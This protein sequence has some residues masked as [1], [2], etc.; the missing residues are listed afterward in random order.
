MEMK[1]QAPD[2]SY[3]LNITRV[4]TKSACALSCGIDPRSFREED[5]KDPGLAE[6]RRRCDWAREAIAA[7]ELASEIDQ[8]ISN[9]YGGGRIESAVMVALT[10]FRAWGESLPRPLTFPDE[11]PQA[12]APANANDICWPWGSYETEL[13]RKLAAAALRF[14]VNYD[15]NDPSTAETNERVAEWLEKEQGVS[16]RRAEV[17]A[18]ILRADGLRTGPR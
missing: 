13:L 17:M 1:M 5:S 3:W 14:W 6:Y 12:K 16:K 11:Y 8:R 15:P 9:Y 7:D 2:W 18:Q 10:D 4:P